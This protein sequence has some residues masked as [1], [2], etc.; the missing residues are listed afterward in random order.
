MRDLAKPVVKAV[1][2][3]VASVWAFL[4]KSNTIGRAVD[5]DVCMM[6]RIGFVHDD[7][8]VGWCRLFWLR[9]LD[10]GWNAV[11][12]WGVDATMASIVVNFAMV[13][14]L[15]RRWRCLM[16]IFFLRRRRSSSKRCEP[17]YD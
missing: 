5:D 12:R 2:C 8:D 15:T 16:S 14:V 13:I 11:V 4:K 3:S 6:G 1:I 17:Y 7:D 9:V 10:G